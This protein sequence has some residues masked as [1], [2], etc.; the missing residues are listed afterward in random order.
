MDQSL[1]L[2]QSA[3]L[4]M[5]QTMRQALK[6][7]QM[8]AA[9]LRQELERA[10]M[11]NPVLETEAID[12]EDHAPESGAEPLPGD[13]DDVLALAV[14]RA[15][16]SGQRNDRSIVAREPAASQGETLF[17]A[18]MEQVD[19][20]FRDPRRHRIAAFLAG[21]LSDN[22]YLTVTTADAAASLHEETSEIDAVLDVMQTFEPCGVAARDLA[23]CLRLQAR[24]LHIYEGLTAAVIDLHLE[25]AAAGQIR[26]IAKEEHCSPADV[27]GCLA[28]L[29][30]LNPK[31]GSSY[32][33]SAASPVIPDVIV[34]RGVDSH[35]RVTLNDSVLPRLTISPVY[36]S[37]GS[38]DGELDRYIRTHL[39]DA[40]QLLR[41]V[42]QRSQTLLRVTE[43]LIRCQEDY[44]TY[45]NGHLHPLTMQ[46]LADRLGLHVS[47]VSRAVS[48]K[49]AALPRGTVSL[50]SFFAAS[51]V[52][53]GAGDMSSEQV[54]ACLAEMIRG[55]DPQKP[56][57]DQK[58]CELLRS[59]QM[60]VSRRTIV[61]YR[62]QMG[63][64]A[65][66]KRKRY[67]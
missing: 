29:R 24:H 67:R 33:R 11:E 39:R 16:E 30:R 22:G 2:K 58:L 9:E 45:G 25:Q 65:S 59:R 55:E 56:L 46:E 43:E 38:G 64:P 20:T 57:S 8:P 62:E 44:V 61:K 36:R 31:P 6:I 34:T 4:V 21:S 40:R 19:V 52:F 1:Q 18:V 13:E 37:A 51:T 48:G 15:A 14:I 26:V 66:F 50:G 5:T 28:V 10:W 27:Q 53:G 47:T 7:L 17:E 49:Y 32:G 41:S 60:D 23:E 12:A 63:I 3:Q 42:R 54:K 35:Y